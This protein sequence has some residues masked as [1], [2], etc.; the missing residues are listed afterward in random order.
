MQR[1]APKETVL[2]ME[3]IKT[4]YPNGCMVHARGEMRFRPEALD[5]PLLKDV[6]NL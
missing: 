5:S 4:K 2:M 1:I 6:F 3:E